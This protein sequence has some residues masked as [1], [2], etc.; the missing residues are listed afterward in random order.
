[1]RTLGFGQGL[2]I[3]AALALSGCGLLPQEPAHEAEPASTAPALSSA[4]EA[5]PSTPIGHVPKPPPPKPQPPAALEAV[6]LVGLS[7]NSTQDLLG[8]PLVESEAGAAKVWMYKAASCQLDVY[9]SYDLARADFY[10]LSYAV[11]R[12]AGT[13][14]AERQCLT[15]LAHDHTQTTRP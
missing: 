13:P 6:Q 14:D 1:M 3:A 2:L 7:R 4:P 9:F 11:N 10:V 15:R 8:P 12:G 5:S